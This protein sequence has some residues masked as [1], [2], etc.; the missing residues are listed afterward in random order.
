M[1]RMAAILCWT[2]GTWLAIGFVLPLA[3]PAT[4][5]K[6]HSAASGAAP[7]FTAADSFVLGA[8]ALGL[9]LFGFLPGTEP[10]DDKD[11]QR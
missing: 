6:I 7:H 1:R 8:P 11:D 3:F 2:V 5:H 4:F 9:S 10:E